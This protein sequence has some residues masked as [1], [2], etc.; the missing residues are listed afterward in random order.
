MDIQ[1]HINIWKILLNYS[2][3]KK[4]FIET[5]NVTLKNLIIK[6]FNTYIISNKVSYSSD[7]QSVAS[8]LNLNLKDFKNK[9]ILLNYSEK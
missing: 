9:S 2:D 8:T 1:K 6:L 7:E 4:L 5:D 3:I